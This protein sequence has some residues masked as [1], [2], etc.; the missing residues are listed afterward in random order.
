MFLDEQ[1]SLVY[2]VLLEI[3]DELRKGLHTTKNFTIEAKDQPFKVYSTDDLEKQATE[4]KQ[5]DLAT[6][7][8]VQQRMKEAE[9]RI[10][11]GAAKVFEEDTKAREKLRA[12]QVPTE[13]PAY[14]WWQ[15]ANGDYAKIYRTELKGE[16]FNE[17]GNL[18]G[19]GAWNPLSNRSIGDKEFDMMK[20]KTG[21][22]PK[23]WPE[24][25]K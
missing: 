1:I 2:Q 16:V 13:P 22:N 3:R 15:L 24:W 8:T 11:V 6:Y 7:A 14:D 19:P 20:R 25:T 21:D 17:E 18:V 9:M 12:T 4:T 5:S 10:Q 23:G